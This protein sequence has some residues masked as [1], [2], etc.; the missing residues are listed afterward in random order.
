MDPQVD[1]NETIKTITIK[2]DSATS[3]YFAAVC[4]FL[5]LLSRDLFVVSVNKYLILLLISIFI[6]SFSL[7]NAIYF[8]CF[9]I[10]LYVGLP[11][12]YITIIMLIKLLLNGKNLK[13]KPWEFITV[14]AAMSFWLMQDLFMSYTSVY[15]LIWIFEIF[16]VLCILST[17]GLNKSQM[18]LMY[19]FGVAITGVITLGIALKTYELQDILT[20]TTRL[21]SNIVNGVTKDLRINIDP[22]YYGLFSIA[23]IS[24]TYPILFDKNIPKAKKTFMIIGASVSLLVG[25][26]GLSR[27]FVITLLIWAALITLTQAG[28][29]NFLISIIIFSLAFFIVCYYFPYVVNGITNRFQQNDLASGNGRINLIR[30]FNTEWLA[31]VWSFLFGVGMYICNVHCMELQYLY[32]GGIILTII[33]LA[34]FCMQIHKIKKKYPKCKLY[35]YIPMCVILI[36]S[37]SIPIATSLTFMFPIVLS[38]YAYD[39]INEK[40]FRITTNINKE[41]E[42]S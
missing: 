11:G 2:R 3:L 25:L 19:T 16:L 4:I 26:I 30:I 6:F 36:I 20:S 23:A 40:T 13:F 28:H 7:N 33:M 27:A 38:I 39:Y 17:D 32:G 15:N 9:L 8:Y 31:S 10:P 14:S 37:S 34:F 42:L 35:S 41:K 18:F 5:I 21:G 24:F 1:R 29:K 12:N 22:N